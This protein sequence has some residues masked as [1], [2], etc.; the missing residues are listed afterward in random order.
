LIRVL[1]LDTSTRWG[2]IALVERGN[3]GSDPVVV[4]ETGFLMG[5][6]HADTLL[7]RV[8]W[9]LSQAGWSK[10]GLD[11]FVATRGPGSFTG[12]R[13]A[14]G[15][16]VGLSVGSG[17]PCVGVGSLEALA[18]AHGPAERE[19]LAVIGA[20]RG[21]LYGQRFDA[22]SSP[23]VPLESPWVGPPSRTAD[24]GGVV[25]IPAPGDDPGPRREALPP[26]GLAVRAPRGAAAAA[27]RI[28]L[29][30]GLDRSAPEE[31]APLYVRPPDA[32][33]KK[34]SP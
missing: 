19:R 26:G 21:E 12:I 30:R 10:S 9:A 8:D 15:T 32:V 28:A 11:A 33:V 23:P 13:V 2:G 7:L 18:E 20:G 31:I 5:R 14:L 16:V 27:G 1:A 6:T 3:D 24:N 29:A 22:A 25:L 34:R 17:R 4:A